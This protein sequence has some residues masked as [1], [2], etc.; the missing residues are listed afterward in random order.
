MNLSVHHFIMEE[1]YP[2]MLMDAKEKIDKGGTKKPSK[3]NFEGGEVVFIQ[4][5]DDSRGSREG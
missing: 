4:S 2:K 3:N 5:E 1:R